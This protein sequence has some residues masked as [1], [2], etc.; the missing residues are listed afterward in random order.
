MKKPKSLP[1]LRVAYVEWEDSCS[2]R[3]WGEFNKERDGPIIIR[4]IGI[5]VHRDKDLLALSTC[6][7]PHGKSA[8]SIAIPVSAIRKVKRVE[9][10]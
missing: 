6:L 9:A 8:D 7:D 10:G 5:V 2:S 3:G 4:S 1:A